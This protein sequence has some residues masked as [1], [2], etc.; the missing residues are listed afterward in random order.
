MIST[1][2]VIWATA[3][4]VTTALSARAA[5]R[6]SVPHQSPPVDGCPG[7][8][9]VFRGGIGGWLPR[10]RR[11]PGCHQINGP[12]W[13]ALAVPGALAGGLLAARLPPQD[14][15]GWALLLAWQVFA[16]AGVVLA[17]IDI[18]VH[19]L[20]T[21]IVTGTAVAITTAIAAASALQ[22]SRDT[23]TGAVL[24]ALAV[25]GSYLLLFILAPG[26][27]GAGDVRLAAITGLALG[28]DTWCTVLLGMV[29]PYLL[30]LPFAVAS[31]IRA[32]GGR[33]KHA[34]IPFGPFL[35]AGS[36]LAAMASR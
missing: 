16:Q 8:D 33:L 22:H 25:G 10:P 29:L 30:C 7:C 14:R 11:C 13:W 21:G 27:I 32:R 34:Q 2:T 26:K 5:F 3:G 35:I 6:L 31:A 19:R 18:A 23:L 36:V 20:P 4:A 24:G 12:P 9:G 17:V 15:A 28:S 1:I